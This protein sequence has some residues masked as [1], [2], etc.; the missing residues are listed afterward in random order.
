M[1]RKVSEAYGGGSEPQEERGGPSYCENVGV[2]Q[3][4]E[5]PRSPE[6]MLGTL[7]PQLEFPT[8]PFSSLL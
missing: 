6:N 8:P 5:P 7:T 1:L 3:I 2:S 4:S